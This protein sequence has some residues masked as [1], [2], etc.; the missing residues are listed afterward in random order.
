MRTKQE[1]KWRWWRLNEEKWEQIGWRR[2]RTEE[3]GRK[4]QERKREKEREVWGKTGP[5]R[6]PC[7]FLCVC[8]VSMVAVDTHWG[9]RLEED[10]GEHTHSSER[11]I[12]AETT[13]GVM[14]KKRDNTEDENKVRQVYLRVY[15]ARSVKLSPMFSP[16]THTHTL[17]QRSIAT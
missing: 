14:K 5:E 4:L 7:V 2:R 12:E 13:R 1:A 8:A 3:E 11:G 15:L 6:C 10:S 17:T 16:H 9:G